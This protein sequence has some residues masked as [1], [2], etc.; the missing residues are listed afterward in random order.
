MENLCIILLGLLS[1]SLLALTLISILIYLRLKRPYN[2]LDQNN[3][4]LSYSDLVLIC[5]AL[6]DSMNYKPDHLY[7]EKWALL[8][9]VKEYQLRFEKEDS[10]PIAE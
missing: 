9:K 1:L 5:R 2:S 4:D 8:L 3:I 7:S 10:A 6:S